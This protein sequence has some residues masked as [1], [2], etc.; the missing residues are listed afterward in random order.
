MSENYE[1]L[2]LPDEGSIFADEFRAAVESSFK[3]LLGASDLVR[4]HSDIEAVRPDSSVLVVYLHGESSIDPR[5]ATEDLAKA[6]DLQ[7]PVLPITWG[8]LDRLPCAIAHI[9]ALDWRADRTAVLSAVLRML[10]LAEFDRKVFL[11][12]VRKDSSSLAVQLHTALAQRQYDVF[13]DRFAVPP[14]ADFQERLEQDLGDKAFVVLL[15]SET[16]RESPWVEYEVSYALGHGVGVLAV[17]LPDV[18]K[19]Q[20]VPA[21]DDSFRVS[22]DWTDFDTRRNELNQGGLRKILDRI[23]WAHARALR[24]RRRELV[25]SISK[26]L[27][28]AGHDLAPVEEWTVLA[29]KEGRDPRIYSVTPRR[30]RPEDLFAL[31]GTKRRLASHMP[32]GSLTASVVHNVALSTKHHDLLEWIST[33]RNLQIRTVLELSLEGAP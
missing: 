4:I 3:C 7:L 2:L 11:S 30:P 5:G 21:I 9:N 16:V 23:E 17:A 24:R 8:Q 31:D 28:Q 12:Y 33:P 15:E 1:I 18:L 6:I 13:L 22:L 32:G 20:R 29:K 14:G 19:A 27:E 10:G 25:G 26:G